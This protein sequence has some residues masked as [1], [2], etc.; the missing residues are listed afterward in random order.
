MKPT[1]FILSRQ[2]E[3]LCGYIVLP[4]RL[5]TSIIAIPLITLL[6]FLL[7]AFSQGNPGFKV[8]KTQHG[9][10]ASKITSGQNQVQEGDLIINLSE[11][12]Y[13][14]VLCS[15]FIPH[16]HRETREITLLRDGKTQT[17]KITSEPLSIAKLLWLVWPGLLLISFFLAL[18]LIV[19][20]KSP[21][22]VQSRL[23]FLM[24]C[25]LSTSISATTASSLGLL[26]PHI[27]SF[28]FLLLTL[29]NWISFGAWLH[30]SLRFPATCDLLQNRNRLS[31]L[32]YTI[33]PVTTIILALVSSNFSIEFWGWLQRYRNLFLPLIIVSAFG[34]HLW[35]YRRLTTIQFKNQLKLPL[36]AYWLT[37]TPY[38]FL[39]LLP[40]LIID[41]PLISF[42]IVIFSFF[43]LPLAY[44]TGLL[45]HGLFEVDRLL[46]RG[47]AFLSLTGLVV[48]SYSLFLTLLKRWFFGNQILSEE[49]FLIFFITI[50]I[51]FYPAINY[52]TGII[53]KVFFR[54][55]P[56]PSEILH[57]F[58]DKISATLFLSDLI[59]AMVEEL[60]E[61]INVDSVAIMLLYDKHS[62]L[63]PDHLRFGTSPWPE[64]RLVETLKN[65]SIVCLQTDDTRESPQLTEEL[66]EVSKAG[67]SLTFPMRTAS[68]L[69][70][71]MYIGSRKDRR[72]F[73]KDDILLIASLANQAAIALENAR[74]HESLVSSN[75][76]IEELFG[77]RVQQEKMAIVGEMTATVAHELKNPLGIIHS[78]AQYL[79]ARKRSESEQQEMLNYIIDE[80]EHLNS[81]IENLL[82][83]A[84]QK[85]PQFEAV[86]LES[87]LPVLVQ[88]W[89]QS[90]D[91]HRDVKISIRMDKYIPLLYG[92][93]HQLN[94]VL[95]NLVRNSE[96]MMVTG[97]TIAIIVENH[98]D[99][100][101]IK[102][103]DNGPGIDSQHIDK[104]F[105]NF[106]TTKDYGLGLGLVVCRQIITA[107]HGTIELNN[108]KNGGAEAKITLP[109]KPLS[110]SG[111]PETK[112]PLDLK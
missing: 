70:G 29:S 21:N 110:T 82:G 20:K 10:L 31:I 71:I 45:R 56:V 76:Q 17:I 57:K 46:S 19:R 58:S 83:L 27:I 25:G 106:F 14:K 28:S 59:R 51:S 94:Q 37:F 24:L 108:V 48:I 9:L 64:S 35:D 99:Q 68:G 38:L 39:Y 75:K 88:R 65:T 63:Y 107:H 102:I 15:L 66:S 112:Y 12:P 61:I 85:P 67:Y 11:V 100:I 103:R 86:N 62:R 109:L 16:L 3:T 50:V 8:D 49:L 54:Y 89:Q 4:Y 1:Q 53:D 77:Q 79:V 95:L 105:S 44:L 30:F 69:S 111:L 42:R 33:P 73:A 26:S 41:R 13:S 81:S 104:I 101:I 91:H 55:S 23:F 5:A 2:A 90:S 98:A 78:S 6:F 97:G 84:K 80:V 60:P 18:A 34:K 74:R 72:L 93:T 7:A 52:L 87:E 40:N 22:S 43:F 92:D 32:I 36:A 96:E 47:L